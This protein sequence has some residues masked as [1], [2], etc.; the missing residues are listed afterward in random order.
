MA[1]TGVGSIDG[2]EA[3]GIEGGTIA[4]EG[5]SRA[6]FTEGGGKVSAV[7]VL[8]EVQP[9]RPIQVA[10][11]ADVAAEKRMRTRTQYTDP[12][13]NGPFPDAIRDFLTGSY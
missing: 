2:T 9:D 3:A 13:L 6:V 8:D 4:C 1:A 11:I 7:S 12:A 5:A 10:R